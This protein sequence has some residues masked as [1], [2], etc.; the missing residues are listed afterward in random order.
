MM[1][2]LALASLH[3]VFISLQ[4]EGRTTLFVAVQLL[5]EAGMRKTD[6]F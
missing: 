3:K 4:Q 6:N 5:F 1:L 2:G